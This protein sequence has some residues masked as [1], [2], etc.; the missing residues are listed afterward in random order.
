[1]VNIKFL[2]FL[3][4]PNSILCSSVNRAFGSNYFVKILWYKQ[5][6]QLLR[7][8]I[9]I[10]SLELGSIEGMMLTCCPWHLFP[11]P[12]NVGLELDNSTKKNIQNN[13]GR[14]KS[15]YQEQCDPSW[16]SLIAASILLCTGKS[17]LDMFDVY[18]IKDTSFC[19][20]L[21]HDSVSTFTTTNRISRFDLVFCMAF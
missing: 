19:S 18:L 13:F 6:M 12:F 21:V 8:M 5:V 17:Y 3:Q 14:V 10:M 1:M 20:F 9:K 4:T 7:Q 16:V 15:R 11:L 2:N